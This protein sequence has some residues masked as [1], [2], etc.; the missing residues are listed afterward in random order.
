MTEEMSIAPSTRGWD[1]TL[2]VDGQDV[3]G[4]AIVDQKVR[5]GN[6]Q[7]KMAGIAGV[8]T[9]E[10][11]RKK[12]YASRVMW[13]SIE[14]MARRKYDVSILFGIA[15]FYHRYGYSACFTSP[16]CQVET[17]QL[18]G[19]VRGF[20][21]RVATK[22]DLPKI[23]SVYRRAHRDRSASTVRPNA[24]QPVH[25]RWGPGWRMPRMAPDVE[26]RPGKAIVA[27]DA[28]GRMIGYAAFDAQAGHCMVTEVGAV[29]RSV[30]PALAHRIRKLAANVNAD[31]VRFCMPVDDSFGAFLGRFGSTW[32]V[33]F[34]KNGGSMGRVVSLGST[35]RRILPTLDDRLS[36]S[37]HKLPGK[38]LTID[39]D[40]GAVTLGLGKGCVVMI[41]EKKGPRVKIGQMAL[42]QML[43]GYRSVEDLAIEG[44]IELPRN[45][46]SLVAALFPKS[47]PY[48][49]WG[50]RF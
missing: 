37:G 24:W 22:R 31:R 10:A 36:R 46:M 30:Y 15:D 34:P 12:G 44:E 48:M 33:H 3:S 29:N 16:I 40:V 18:K 38:G 7:L 45:Q 21:V 47:N 14:E 49:W 20:K 1:V 42:T 4:L 5:V 19:T 39:T 11:H 17:A 35:L 25:G 2:N 6:G 9:A 26:R 32:T 27:E 8:W 23:V 13:A 43:F 28:S 41:G 50:D